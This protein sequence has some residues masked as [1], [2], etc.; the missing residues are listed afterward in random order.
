MSRDDS[1][2]QI[3]SL[4]QILQLGHTIA[5]QEAKKN[6]PSPTTAFSALAMSTRKPS[7]RR[8]A[9]TPSPIASSHRVQVPNPTAIRR[10]DPVDGSVSRLIKVPGLTPAA[11]GAKSKKV[12][13][14]YT[15][16]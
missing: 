10:T 2:L 12:R 14:N 3:K 5:L 9:R 11:T 6:E 1:Q 7:P 15:H 8:I 16:C 13:A 4:E